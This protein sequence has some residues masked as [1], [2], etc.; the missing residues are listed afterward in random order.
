MCLFTYGF[1]SAVRAGNKNIT[2]F[3]EME[4]KSELGRAHTQNPQVGYTRTSDSNDAKRGNVR[5]NAS[6]RDGGASNHADAS[7]KAPR[8]AVS[9]VVPVYN[10]LPYLRPALESLAAQTLGAIEF[11]CVNDGSTDGS[12]AVLEEFAA[13]DARFSVLDRENGGYGRA[14]NIGMDAAAGDYIGI[15]EPDDVVPPEMFAELF[16][17]AQLED[18]KRADIVKS[19]FYQLYDGDGDH[20]MHLIE[21]DLLGIG[22]PRDKRVVRAADIPTVFMNHPSIWT[23]IY[24]A[25][26]LRERGIRFVEAPGAGWVD[27]PFLFETFCQAETIVWDPRPFY[28][29]RR[30]NEN[31]S[32]YL[33][34][35]QIPLDRTDEILDLRDSLPIRDRYIRMI[36]AKRSFY[37]YQSILNG[38]DFDA[39]DPALWERMSAELA[40]FSPREVMR[41]PHLNRDH[42]CFY[43]DMT[44]RSLKKVKRRSAA[45]AGA[46]VRLSV[47][48]H[49]RNRCAYVYEHLEGLLRT[50]PGEAEF[51]WQDEG[52]ST[53]AT[54]RFVEEI[55]SRDGRVR[56]RTAP[57]ATLACDLAGEWVLF[58]AHGTQIA[59]KKALGQAMDVLASTKAGLVCFGASRTADKR[60]GFMEQDEAL[61][62]LFDCANGA[63]SDVAV[64]RE[65][66]AGVL[67]DFGEDRCGKGAGADGA[68]NA[69]G[70]G[71]NAGSLLADGGREL[72][73][74]LALSARD[75]IEFV[76]R[77]VT[78]HLHRSPKVPSIV[79]PPQ[80]ADI[81][82]T[83]VPVLGRIQTRIRRHV[84]AADRGACAGS[85]AGAGAAA[86]GAG[87]GASDGKSAA[88]GA[89]LG[90]AAAM[91]ANFAAYAARLMVADLD[92]AETHGAFADLA[93]LFTEKHIPALVGDIERFA[94][95]QKGSPLEL[96]WQLQ[97]GR[98]L[99][100]YARPEA[101]YLDKLVG[102]KALVQRV[103]GLLVKFSWMPGPTYWFHTLSRRVSGL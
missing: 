36:I 41:N 63:M 51:V 18:G 9:V 89:S 54:R 98:D 42:V 45:A 71:A 53:D 61:G 95:L 79:L 70:G 72:F 43:R 39:F 64:R 97:R 85:S 93:G 49:G 101:V 60:C 69:A 12:L 88:P 62:V 6:G 10:A 83:H 34:N 59:S 67:A 76:E 20:P 50:A 66:L 96:L 92:A 99:Y 48:S 4:K 2:R 22:L 84:E 103:R 81:A 82:K 94:P 26:F 86:G 100:L 16:A 7:C 73:A 35:W 8:P 29:Y 52:G 68:G 17:D 77:P 5:E 57:D 78:K 90:L 25:D 56:Y 23:C 91:E 74:A 11:V 15:L 31:A 87:G 80:A 28:R 40:R 47:V 37:Y 14:M 3:R 30:T 32:S 46:P 75:G 33:K 44:G 102:R 38:M 27:N 24:R 1:N 65:L 58:T 19:S 55:A 21:R 13:R